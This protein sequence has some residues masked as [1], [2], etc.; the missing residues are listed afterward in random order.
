MTDI[1]QFKFAASGT[2]QFL[3]DIMTFNSLTRTYTFT[4]TLDTSVGTWQVKIEAWP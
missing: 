1:A 2:P 3:I 4:P